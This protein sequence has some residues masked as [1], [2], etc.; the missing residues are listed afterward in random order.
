MFPYRRW[1]GLLSSFV[2]RRAK[3]KELRRAAKHRPLRVEP[4]EERQ[5]L[6]VSAP[7]GIGL[8]NPVNSNFDLRHT[9]TTGNADLSFGYGQG[10]DGWKAVMGDWNGD[11][12]DTAGLYDPTSASFFNLRNSNS[13]GYADIQVAFGQPDAGWIPIAGDWD[14]VGGGVDTI[15]LYEPSTGTYYLRNSNTTGT[16]DATFFFGAANWQPLAGDWNGDGIDSIGGWY[17]PDGSFYLRNSNSYGNT[18]IYVTIVGAPTTNVK[19]IAGDWNGDGIYSVGLYHIPTATFYLK[20]TNAWGPADYVFSYGNLNDT[21]QPI[22]GHWANWYPTANA[23]TYSVTEDNV[24]TVSAPGVLGNDADPEGQ[25]MTAELVSS[26]S[27]SQGTLSLNSNGSFTYTPAANFYGTASFTYRTSPGQVEV[28]PRTATVSINVN[29]VPDPPTLTS[30][31][32]LNGS[33]EDNPTTITYAALAAAA[34]EADSDSPTISFRVEGVSSG[35]LTKNGSAVSPGTTLL[36][37]GEQLVWTPAANANGT[38]AAFSVKAWDGALVSTTAAVQVNVSVA[39]V[40][41]PPTLDP[42]ANPSPIGE[43]APEQ[44][45]HDWGITAGGGESQQI[46]VTATSSN[47]AIIPHPRVEYTYPNSYAWFFYTPVPNAYGTAVITVTVRDSGLDLILGNGDDATAQRQVTVTV[48]PGIDPPTLNLIG[49]PPAI[50]EDA[51][52]QTVSLSGIYPPPFDPPLLAVYASSDNTAL[53]P[54]PTVN[55]TSPNST[56][57]LTYTPVANQSGTATITVTA[58]SGGANGVLGGGDDGWLYR[59]FTVTVNPVNDLPTMDAISSPP[60]I[61]EDAPQQAIN[62][63]GITAGGG[64][65]QSLQVTASSSN[66]SLIPTPTVIDYSYNGN[67]WIQYTP[68]ANQS[69]T[70]VITVTVRDAGLDLTLGN[71]DDGTFQRTFTVT[72]QAVNDTPT[73]DAIANPAAINEDA[74]QQQINLSGISAGGGE[75]QALKILVSSSNTTLI[76]TPTVSYTSPNATGAI[77]YTPAA[78]KNGTAEITVTVEDA[79]LNGILDGVDDGWLSRTFTVVVNSVNDAPILDNTG[80]T[81][82]PTMERN[83]VTNSGITIGALVASAGGDRITDADPADLEGIAVLGVDNSHGTW[84]Y[85]LD[86]GANWFD[87]GT[88]ST[89][90]AR[91]LAADANTRIRLVPATDWHGTLTAGLTF[92]AWDRTV[93]TN[94]ETAD[95]TTGG[96]ATPFSTAT[97][98]ASIRVNAVPTLTSVATL[99]GALEDAAFS[100]PYQ[101]LADAADES[102]L[103]DSTVTFRVESVLNGTLTKNGQP[104]VAGSTTLAPGEQWSWTPTANANGTFAGITVKAGDPLVWSASP[105]SVSIAVAAMNDAPIRTT[106]TVANLTVL[107]DAAITTLGLGSVAYGPGGGTDEAGQ[108]LTYRVTSVP[109]ASLGQVLLAD[110]TTP[111]VVGS[112]SLAEIRGMQF[113][114]AADANGSAAFSF[115]V[116]DDGGTPGS[117]T[118]TETLTI[119][120]TPVNDA[121]SFTVGASQLVNEDCGS[122]TVAGWATAIS[123]GPANESAQA[124][125]F[126]VTTNKSGLFVAGPTIDPT[127]GTLTYTPAAN[128]YGV[129]HVNVCLHDNGSGMDTS[130]SYSFTIG[131]SAVNDSPAVSSLTNQTINEDGATASLGFTVSDA[132]TPADRLAITAQSSNP[133]VVPSANVAVTGSGTNRSVIIT[134]AANASGIASISLTVADEHGTSTTQ[135]FSVTVNSTNDLPVISQIANAAIDR[136]TATPAYRFTISDVETDPT[137]LTLTGG[138]SN[139]AVVS[140]GNIVFGGSGSARMVTITPTANAAGTTTITI[141]AT[142]GQGGGTQ[143]SFTLTVGSLP[144]GPGLYNA[145]NS[146]FYFRNSNTAG[147][148]EW[149]VGF[150]VQNDGWR[151]VLGDWNN[152]QLDT[153]GLYDPTSASYF[154]MRNDNRTGEHQVS[155]G[156]GIENAG[157][158]PIAGDW[159]WPAI[160]EQNSPAVA[161]DGV[162]TVGLY[163]QDNCAFRLRNSNESGVADRTFYMG[164][165]NY[166]WLPVAGDWDGDGDD[167][168]GLFDPVAKMFYLVNVNET[169]IADLSFSFSGVSGTDLKPVVGDWNGDGVDTVGLYDNATGTFYL[170]N[171]HSSGD[172]DSVFTFQPATGV[173]YYPIGGHWNSAP[174]ISAIADQQTAEDTPLTG[175]T[176]TVGDAQ[177]TTD[178][179]TLAATSSD[180]NIVPNSNIVLG[181]SGSNRTL[182]IT[183]AENRFGTVAITLALTDDQGAV[184]TKTF[185]LVVTSV[186]DQPIISAIVDQIT[187]RN[188]A[189]RPIHFTVSDAETPAYGLTVEVLESDNTTLVPA[190]NITLGGSESDRSLT[191]VPTENLLGNAEV[192]L[193]VTDGDGLSQTVSAKLAVVSPTST[194]ALYNTTD[195]SFMFRYSNTS[196]DAN[197][198]SPYGDGTWLPVTGDWN[199]DTLDT[200]GS[201]DPEASTFYLRNSTETG[202]ADL[203]FGY[204]GGGWLPI[205]GDWDGD[206]DDSVGLYDPSASVF[207]LTKENQSGYAD[208]VFGFGQP[209]ANWIPIAGD[210][211]GDGDDSVGLYDPVTSTFYLKNS[212]LMGYADHIFGFGQANWKPIAGDWD[213]DGDDSIGLYDPASSVF[214]LRSENNSGYANFTFGYGQP[215][216]GWTPLAGHWSDPP[217][218]FTLSPAQVLENCSVGTTVGTFGTPDPNEGENLTYTLVQGP[219][220]NDNS[221]FTIEGNVLNTAVTFNR[222][223]RSTYR[224]RVRATGGLQPVEQEFDIEITNQNEPATD[225]TLSTLS[226][227]ENR[228]LGTVVG[229][230]G[231]NDPDS[232]NTFTYSLVPGSGAID[233]GSFQIVNTGGNVYQL[234]TSAA[235]DRETRAALSIRVRCQDQAGLGTEKAFTLTVNDE[236]ES[237]SIA[238]VSA[239][240]TSEDTPV[241]FTLALSDPD[242]P[243]GSLTLSALSGDTSLVAVNGITFGGTGAYRTMTVRPVQNQS[244]AVDIVVTANDHEGKTSTQTVHIIVNPVDDAPTDIMLSGTTIAEGL[245]AGTRIG[246]LSA[247][248]PDSGEELTYSLAS[249]SDLFAIEAIY[250]E[251]YETY[252]YY[253]VSKVN[254]DYESQSSHSVTVGAVDPDGHAYRETFSISI[255]NVTTPTISIGDYRIMEGDVARLQVTLSDPSAN[256][257]EVFFR[258]RAYSLLPGDT[259]SD[260][261]SPVD[262]F[263]SIPPNQTTC[264]I[265]ITAHRNTDIG[266]AKTFHTEISNISTNVTPGTTSSVVTIL[267]DESI[268]KT[269]AVSDALVGE[270]GVATFTISLVTGRADENLCFL[271]QTRDGSATAAGD[272]TLTGNVACIAQGARSVEVTVPIAADLV[273]EADEMFYLDISPWSGGEFTSVSGRCLITEGSTASLLCAPVTVTE[274]ESALFEVYAGRPNGFTGWVH[275]VASSGTATAE[276]DFLRPGGASG[277]WL[278]FGNYYTFR[279]VVV[280]TIP[281]NTVEPT[282]D[283]NL[284][285]SM[286][287]SGGSPIVLQ[288]KGYITDE[289]DHIPTV[290]ITPVDT[291]AREVMPDSLQPDDTATFILTR[292]GSLTSSLFVY[293]EF[294]GTANRQEYELRTTQETITQGV[295]LPADSPSVEITLAALYDDMGGGDETAQVAIAPVVD[296]SYDVGPS[297]TADF[298]LHD[299]STCSPPW[300]YNPQD[301]PFANYTAVHPDIPTAGTGYTVVIVMGGTKDSWFYNM[302]SGGNERD[303]FTSQARAA[304]PDA[305]I[306]NDL[307]NIDQFAS[308]V[309]AFPAGSINR[310]IL[311]GHGSQFVGLQPTNSNTHD[312]PG[313]G[314]IDT[315]TL[316]EL[317]ESTRGSVIAALAGDASVTV[318][319]C[320]NESRDEESDGQRFANLI[321]RHTRFAIGKIYCSELFTGTPFSSIY[322]T[323][324][325]VD[326]YP[327]DL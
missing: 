34:N 87:F 4:L 291:V 267:D 312:V 12:V 144:A 264:E 216:A 242:T 122:Q 221:C 136:N 53:I 277:G 124:L 157:W 158:M 32:T 152:D 248:N 86:G 220:A 176:F 8:Y 202:Y 130:P 161:A 115:Q 231:N 289:T 250:N 305:Y 227:L 318:Y 263:Y 306:Y 288:T 253:L 247:V 63:A 77:Y 24:L 276:T 104:V 163:D 175:A 249:G 116:Q 69:G 147:P 225:I 237:P 174:T 298:T 252:T 47:T 93:G 275:Y 96:G 246:T 30:I 278:Y 238:P 25:A 209:G 294:G 265:Q 179:L 266:A 151:P 164:D 296:G 11:C 89:T 88:P 137:L 125:D 304:F 38:L 311:A 42:I 140:S 143:M 14:G 197:R 301:L 138:S 68:V 307:Y 317:D 72:V 297:S 224:I 57:S 18:D 92:K 45:F 287:I 29:N 160:E 37:P 168:V 258:Y 84:Q 70:A 171:S 120:V 308:V 240:T 222:E 114:P 200:L 74:G 274:G 261:Y 245:P 316:G 159:S 90:V 141:G 134:P 56:G 7:D 15:G 80:T 6:T 177:S 281:D 257:Q 99:T 156:F 46:S 268:P 302:L 279:D 58:R 27:P 226:V 195:A 315:Q 154:W 75:P 106:G 20:N 98:T 91:L 109:N 51:G 314:S 9:N 67:A 321:Q 22:A 105:V 59:T 182:T 194:I 190:N 73:L 108:S 150:G 61:W 234:K 243:V 201:Y 26:V 50:N 280:T 212:N 10:N 180:T 178:Q 235:F 232:G 79:G 286:E 293:L 282:E 310:L 303:D 199:K 128:A 54:N 170:K 23:N 172:A 131:I 327:N 155:F 196:G 35:T 313:F 165:T 123:A 219:T 186:P 203:T 173:T 49:N 83:P 218:S 256:G 16:A 133:A 292:T 129:A 193:K 66:T 271:Y 260:D 262:N 255:T 183:P 146:N 228:P 167:T 325:W 236:N 5:L 64:E 19:A 76:P 43:D 166:N 13:A 217:P 319:S 135:T 211:D 206:G 21:R 283:F 223:S 208:Y 142:D 204:G 309:G 48:N 251:I 185:S 192:T 2:G 94:G 126:V 213:G 103:D 230:L 41:D 254:F 39:A 111:V 259:S 118:L 191:I 272:Y 17:P 187:T 299:S 107:E 244:G 40:N 82:L 290:Q 326:V 36:G 44:A 149:T 215:N 119:T 78:N 60:A 1:S 198:T 28:N 33:V 270:G 55:Y 241:T 31:S 101:T 273:P 188:S 121:P 210:W 127:T 285:L 110:G 324:R 162:D 117:D 300:P 97:E 100:I 207:Y 3:H 132:E 85:S 95:A 145:T 112:Y 181:G 71:G 102:D 205:A 153:V 169:R 148:A 184:A 62:V 189:T 295:L 269:L 320:G 233:N 239:G 284:T 214:Y 229:V 323:G 81:S 65:S 52:T 113:R 139:T 322:A